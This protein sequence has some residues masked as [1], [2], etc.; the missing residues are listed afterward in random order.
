MV[1]MARTGQSLTQSLSSSSPVPLQTAIALLIPYVPAASTLG[2]SF[3]PLPCAPPQLPLSFF[4][5]LLLIP[6]NQ[7]LPLLPPPSLLPLPHPPSLTSS[8]LS[9]PFP[10]PPSLPPSSSSFSPSSSFS[11]SSFPGPSSLLDFYFIL[12][13]MPSLSPNASIDSSLLQL[14]FQIAAAC[15]PVFL[16]CLL[17]NLS[18]PSL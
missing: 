3:L 13:L 2:E 11:S 4:L 18:L 1:I 15:L 10:H 17:T 5:F 9:P 16:G 7:P 6:Q 8:L 12:C 14:V